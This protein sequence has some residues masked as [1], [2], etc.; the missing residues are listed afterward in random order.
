MSLQFE[1]ILVCV[2]TC[3]TGGAELLLRRQA[4]PLQ[5]Q[6]AASGWSGDPRRLR[7]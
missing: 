5:E 4:R 7:D 1:T 3:D 2:L 6:L